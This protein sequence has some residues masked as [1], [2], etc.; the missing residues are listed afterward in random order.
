VAPLRSTIATWSEPEI[1]STAR[2]P[3][4]IDSTPMST[5]TTPA[6]PISATTD[7]AIRCD[8]LRRFMLVM[9]TT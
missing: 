5:V 9:A 7:E 3:S 4:A 6:M 8:I 1:S 2:K